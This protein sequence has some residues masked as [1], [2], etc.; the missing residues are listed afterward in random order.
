MLQCT[1]AA[2]QTLVN[3]RE[4]QG[5]PDTVGVRLFPAQTPDGSTGLGIEL[6]EPAEGDQVSEQHGT[7]LIVAPE[8]AEQLADMTLDVIP[9]PTANGD[10]PGQLVLRRAEG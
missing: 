9:D 2:A 4:Q 5:L 8:I 1:P 3:V 7:Q 10:A 6:T